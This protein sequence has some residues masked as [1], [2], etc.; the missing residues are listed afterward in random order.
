MR[1]GEGLRQRTPNQLRHVV[2]TKVQSQ[3]S[4]DAARAILGH[5]SAQMTTRYA[6]HDLKAASEIMGAIG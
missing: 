1:T 6:A 4:L 3:Y 5:S 2:A